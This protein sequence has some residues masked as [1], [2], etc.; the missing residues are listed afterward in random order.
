VYDGFFINLARS[1]ERR[2]TLQAHLEQLG[3][4]S[5]YR[6]FDAVDGQ[7][8]SVPRVPGLSPAAVGCWLSH[9]GLLSSRRGAGRHVHII[10][11]DIVLAGDAARLLDQIVQIADA[12]LGRWDMLF[13][14]VYVPLDIPTH[15]LFLA[16]LTEFERTAAASFVD[17]AGIA[18]AGFTSY[19]VNWRSIDKVVALV[20]RGLKSGQP[21]DVHVRNL[22]ARHQ[23]RA[24][25]TLPFLSCPAPIG[26]KASDIRGAV[27]RSRQVCDTYRRGFFIDANRLCLLADLRQVV[28]DTSVDESTE[29]FL[30]A[31]RFSLSNQWTLF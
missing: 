30:Q 27:D 15:R 7:T 20:T 3:L 16:Q 5:R 25:V 28:A 2:A 29:L 4:G 31:L 13:T 18:F 12:R 24:H 19:F 14:D 6:R 9:L 11:D 23:L 1:H 10:E 26:L 17:L 8:E 21:I 22:A